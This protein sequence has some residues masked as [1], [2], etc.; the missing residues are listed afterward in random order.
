MISQHIAYDQQHLIGGVIPRSVHIEWLP[1]GF[2]VSV[3]GPGTAYTKQIIVT[4]EE[5]AKFV[6]A[7]AQADA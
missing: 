2:L 7:W 3:A 4:A 5:L 1:G 6:A